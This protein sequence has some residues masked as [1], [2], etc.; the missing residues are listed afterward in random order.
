MKASRILFGVVTLIAAPLV[1]T[2]TAGTASAENKVDIATG[3][4]WIVVTVTTDNANRPEWC[5]VD[6]YFGTPQTV[7]LGV[8]ES[9][10]L[11][12]DNVPPGPHRVSVWCPNGGATMHDVVV[13][14]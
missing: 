14:G 2:A 9:G 10:N 13:P 5:R 1:M 11:F 8:A 4:K 6:P 7:S 3:K 12:V